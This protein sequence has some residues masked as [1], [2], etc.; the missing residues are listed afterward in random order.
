MVLEDSI[1]VRRGST[2]EQVGEDRGSKE[3]DGCPLTDAISSVLTMMAAGGG[4][5]TA[6]GMVKIVVSHTN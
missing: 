2:Y 6:G 5:L 1:E 3:T 4:V